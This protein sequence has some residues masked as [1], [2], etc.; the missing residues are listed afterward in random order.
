MNLS[1]LIN[2]NVEFS[3]EDI[4]LSTNLTLSTPSSNRIYHITPSTDDLTITLPSNT[5]SGLYII[6]D[7]M[8]DKQL[9]IDGNNDSYEL[10]DANAIFYNP[11]T[12][13][14][15]AL[16]LDASIWGN[17]T[18]T[19]L[20]ASD[21]QA[22]DWFG[23]S[24]SISSDGNTCIVG[25]IFEDT[26]GTNVGAAYIFTRSGTTWIEQ[27]KLMASDAQASDQFGYSCSI[28]SDGNTC[29]VGA[30]YEDTGGT[31]AGAVYIFT[32]SGST[33]TE[34]QK[35]MASDAEANDWFGQS[36]SISG[37]GNTCVVGT[38]L[39]DTGSTDA[40]AAYI[41]TR[42]GSTWTQQ[43]KLMASD[44]SASDNFGQSCSIS[45]D[46]NTCIVGAA[47]EDTGGTD[48]GASYIFTRSGSTWTQQAKLMASD[49]QANDLFGYSCSISGD[50]NACVVGARYEDT[51]GDNA[52]AA[53]IFTKS[54]STW[55]QHA[56]LM[57]SDGQADDWFGY[58]C[59]ISSDGNTCIVGARYEVTNGDNAGAVYVFTRSGST[60]TQ[61]QK[62]M[63]SDAEAN[64]WFGYSCSISSDGNTCVV[65]AR[66][67]DTGGTDAGAVYIFEC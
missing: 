22:D 15:A 57:A 18:Q 20:M 45:S 24:C 42:S 31:N 9:I 16:N 13:F 62:L 41:F 36:C 59:S 63:A 38:V 12:G 7:N 66:F 34:Q 52:G 65:G 6:I 67:E 60:W 27:Q 23:Y 14:V 44:A 54:G 39:E 32:R 2:R 30:V 8:T 56:K 1:D 25:A 48:A 11:T 10:I 5:D 33:W 47:Y 46:G 58:S 55:T 49:A 51:N 4:A 35:L 61:Q 19:K 50:G 3:E 40:G 17:H 64:D 43:A 37:D 26:G 21:A 29:V 28:S 53:Y